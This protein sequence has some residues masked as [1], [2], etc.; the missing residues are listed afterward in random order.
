M[1]E[2]IKVCYVLSY[3][4]PRYIRARAQMAALSQCSELELISA[5]NTHKGLTR[6]LQTLWAVLKA[7]YKENPDVYI[8]GFRGHELFWL[9]RLLVWRKPLIFDA[10]MSPYAALKYE[11]K[12]GR[13]GR[14]LAPIVRL[15]ESTA[16]KYADFVLTDTQ[17]HVNY[18]AQEF[19]VPTE[20]IMAIPVGAV[21][22]A[23]NVPITAKLEEPFTVL[24]Y[25]SFLPLHGVDVIIRAASLLK[26]QPIHF[27]FIGGNSVQIKRLHVLCE[28]LGVQAYTHR[29]W[30]PFDQLIQNEIPQ[31]DLCLGGPFGSTPQARRVITTKTSQCLALAKPVVIGAIDEDVGF[32]DKVN[33]LLVEQGNPE[34]LAKTIRWA[35]EHKKDLSNLGVR[36][37]VLY[38]RS[39]ST[40]VILEK[41]TRA[42][43]VIA[44]IKQ[45]R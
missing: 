7:K 4:D 40:Q 45:K 20:K 35:Y 14:A 43:E 6:Y 1:N 28:Q 16:L 8:L 37:K 41:L 3:R 39:L 26:D 12:S 9:I 17:L 18:Y 24:F 21:E 23:T 11:N 32:E 27:D 10:L 25:G 34:S 15:M 42:F 29:A 33:C 13:L 44:I 19:N 38:Q 2:P 22:D 31:A 5:V 30:V 36:G